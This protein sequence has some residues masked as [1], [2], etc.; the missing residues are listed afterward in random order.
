MSSERNPGSGEPDSKGA[1]EPLVRPLHGDDPAFADADPQGAADDGA[2]DGPLVSPAPAPEAA[3]GAESGA[4]PGT[5]TAGVSAADH[6]LDSHNMLPPRTRRRSKLERFLVRLI[7]TAGIVAIGVA[8]AAIMVSQHSHGWIVG[9]VV[10]AVSV[11]LAA[12]LWSSRQL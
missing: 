6:R 11:V 1:E 8:I 3:P 10:S 9:L 7:A 12:V 5:A 4:A 2:A